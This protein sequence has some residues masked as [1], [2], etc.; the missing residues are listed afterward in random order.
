MVV[1]NNSSIIYSY[2]IKKS[3]NTSMYFGIFSLEK[4]LVISNCSKS[5][6]LKIYNLF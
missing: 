2:H 3:Q 4:L 1:I 6:N 5:K